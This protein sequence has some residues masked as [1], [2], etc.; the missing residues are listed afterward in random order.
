MQ[1]AARHRVLPKKLR[2]PNAASRG[3]RQG[4][5]Q[6]RR[7]SFAVTFVGSGTGDIMIQHHIRIFKVELLAVLAGFHRT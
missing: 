6:A 1:V 7:E 4:P 5:G 3:H 2:P